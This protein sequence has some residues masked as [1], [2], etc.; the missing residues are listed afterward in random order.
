MEEPKRYSCGNGEGM[1]DS[2]KG[3]W[4][5]YKEHQEIVNKIEAAISVTRCCEE[6]GCGNCGSKDVDKQESSCNNCNEYQDY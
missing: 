4:I 6:F 3:Y 1:F 5:S 2:D